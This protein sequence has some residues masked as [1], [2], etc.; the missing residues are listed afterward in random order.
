MRVKSLLLALALALARFLF[1]RVSL[2]RQDGGKSI[3]A[4]LDL[5][6]GS[7]FSLGHMSCAEGTG[8]RAQ[9]L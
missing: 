3:A 6:S 1:G 9:A 5:L 2:L 7:S 8:R 4:L